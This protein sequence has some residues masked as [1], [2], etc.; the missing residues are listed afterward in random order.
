VFM[1]MVMFSMSKQ[2]IE[3]PQQIDN[4]TI[5]QAYK[6]QQQ[7]SVCSFNP[8]LDPNGVL[9]NV[10]LLPR[11]MYKSLLFLSKCYQISADY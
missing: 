11:S 8:R 9:S 3:Q 2:H 1:L 4:K 10:E 7:L 6:E 5:D